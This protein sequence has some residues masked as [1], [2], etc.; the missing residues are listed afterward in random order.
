M[1]E[2]MSISKATDMTFERWMNGYDKAYDEFGISEYP[3]MKAYKT[4]P[5]EHGIVDLLQYR[6]VKSKASN[7]YYRLIRVIEVDGRQYAVVVPQTAD[8][9]DIMIYNKEEFRTGYKPLYTCP[10]IV[11]DYTGE[12]IRN[13]FKLD[14]DMMIYSIEA[15]RMTMGKENGVEFDA[16]DVWIA[17]GNIEERGLGEF[18]ETDDGLRYS[19]FLTPYN[20]IEINRQVMIDLNMYLWVVENPWGLRTYG[21]EFPKFNPKTSTEIPL[22]GGVANILNK[23]ALPDKR[24]DE[25]IAVLPYKGRTYAIV[26]ENENFIHSKICNEDEV[27][28]GYAPLEACCVQIYDCDKWDGGVHYDYEGLE[29]SARTVSE[30]GRMCKRALK[31]TADE[32][33]KARIELEK[34]TIDELQVLVCIADSLEA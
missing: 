9:V 12:D 19:F 14:E 3:T 33:N 18:E 5:L 1:N 32:V 20:Q 13:G 21:I 16:F 11:Y 30:N 24:Q 23:D 10:V 26:A 4:L 31:F 2:N 28:G 15:E 29:I 8:Y 25:L 27:I 17:M 34:P 6:P 7:Y 22:V